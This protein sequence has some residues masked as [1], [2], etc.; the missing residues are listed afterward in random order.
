MREESSETGAEIQ[1]VEKEPDEELGPDLMQYDNGEIN[2]VDDNLEVARSAEITEI[3]LVDRLRA[4]RARVNAIPSE[5]EAEIQDADGMNDES[6]LGPDLMPC[7]SGRRNMKVKRVKLVAPVRLTSSGNRAAAKRIKRNGR[8]YG[9]SDR[10]VLDFGGIDLEEEADGNER[11]GRK[12]ARFHDLSQARCGAR[13]QS[14]GVQCDVQRHRQD[15]QVDFDV[16]EVGAC[17]G[18]TIRPRASS[19]DRQTRGTARGGGIQP[20]DHEG[21]Q[22]QGWS[23]EGQGGVRAILLEERVGAVGEGFRG[24][25]R[26]ARGSQAAA[27]ED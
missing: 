10:M 6:E 8:K 3:R 25:V 12:K 23:K 1:A 19:Q 18:G 5:P 27:D 4:V 17:G 9:R 11:V 24:P 22:A 13:S 2:E 21:A 20:Q 26:G 16:G 7:E 15:L 14:T